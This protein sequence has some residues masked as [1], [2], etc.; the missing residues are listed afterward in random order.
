MKSLLLKSLDVHVMKFKHRNS[1]SIL[2]MYYLWISRLSFICNCLQLQWQMRSYCILGNF[3]GK[4]ISL[5][6]RI[7]LQPQKFNYAKI[8]SS[9]IINDSYKAILENLFAKE[10]H[11]RKV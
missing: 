6:L 11:P 3:Q 5:F 1:H 10:A 2:C 8:A 9:I 7:C 4:I